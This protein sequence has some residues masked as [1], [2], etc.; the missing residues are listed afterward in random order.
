MFIKS[1]GFHTSYITPGTAKYHT[2]SKESKDLG[3]SCV[4]I[5]KDNGLVITNTLGLLWTGIDRRIL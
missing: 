2:L 5:F 3:K 4:R 1:L